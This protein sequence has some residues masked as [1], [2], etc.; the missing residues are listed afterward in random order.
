[1]P[2]RWQ[3]NKR[4]EPFCG[5]RSTR[6]HQ[7]WPRSHLPC[8]RTARGRGNTRST[9]DCPSPNH[10]H[11]ATNRRLHTTLQRRRSGPHWSPLATFYYC[12]RR[13]FAHRHSHD[14]PVRAWAEV[15][16]FPVLICLLFSPLQ[17]HP[18][19]AECIRHLRNGKKTREKKRFAPGV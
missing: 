8:S 3:K 6:P 19:N 17:V 4:P 15:C 12:T 2:S 1:M 5:Q 18:T 13:P 11:N 7:L 16:L 9:D 10:P 14:T